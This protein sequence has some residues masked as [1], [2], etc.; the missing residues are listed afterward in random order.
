MAAK[1]DVPKYYELEAFR[2]SV[3]RKL[4]FGMLSLTIVAI[5]SLG[6]A[7][8]AFARPIPVVAFDKEGRALL[9]EDTVRPRLQLEDARIEYFAEEFL[10]LYVGVD[11]A[12]LDENLGK[13]LAMMT[14]QF[15]QAVSTDQAELGRRKQ[16]ESQNLQSIF[17]GWKVQIGSYD[18]EDQGG[19]V[20]L[21]VTGQMRF[22]PRFGEL[23]GEGEVSRSFLS[24]LVLQRVPVTKVSI[25]GLLVDFVHTRIFASEKELE[26]FEL[27]QVK[28]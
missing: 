11:S 28:K 27:Q 23:E 13:A 15:R 8:I 9:F 16:Y 2:R 24:Q 6:L 20:H 1:I 25:H 26:A 22:E 4:W 17:G 7:L 12:S 5:L 21:L 18:P 19:K 14:P 10:S 3:N